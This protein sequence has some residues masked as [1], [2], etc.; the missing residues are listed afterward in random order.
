MV[1]P[2][3]IPT[4]NELRAR[5]AELA[6]KRARRGAE[7]L[8]QHRPG[9]AGEIDLVLLDVGVP[10]RC[11]LAQTH[12]DYLDGLLELAPPETPGDE[13]DDFAFHF[14]FDG[15]PAH[16]W[17]WH[18]R[19]CYYA[20]LTSAWRDEVSR[21]A[22]RA[23]PTPEREREPAPESYTE[24]R[25][26]PADRLLARIECD[27]RAERAAAVRL[28]SLAMPSPYGSSPTPAIAARIERPP[29]LTLRDL[30]PSDRLAAVAGG[31]CVGWVMFGLGQIADWMTR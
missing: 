15:P 7:L 25:P 5:R 31:L 17:G 22:T 8:D 20:D 13:V 19:K 14:G 1:A 10:E 28:P 24:L 12:G 21:R 30:S 4:P 27:L 26:L 6:C 9:W 16:V 2:P 3:E 11:I 29:S 18:E 23:E